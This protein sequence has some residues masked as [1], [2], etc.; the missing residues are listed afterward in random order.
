MI[1]EAETTAS[2]DVFELAV[3]QNTAIY[4]VL[5]CCQK[6]TAI[7][8]VFN[9]MVGKNTAICKVFFYIFA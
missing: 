4:S 8:D 5:T 7:C 6:N 9:N 1:C 3:A 2:S